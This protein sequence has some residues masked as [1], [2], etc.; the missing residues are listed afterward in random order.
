MRKHL[1]EH[2][3]PPIWTSKIK[4]QSSFS[5]PPFWTVF[6]KFYIDLSK[7]ISLLVSLS[8]S[9]G[10]QHGIQNQRSGAKMAAKHCAAL[11]FFQSWFLHAFGSPF[12]N[13]LVPVAPLLQDVH[14][15]CQYITKKWL[16]SNCQHPK[17]GVDSFG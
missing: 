16:P 10:R 1:F 6:V 15:F 12:G 13:L 8:K 3:G 7:K 11:T 17:A 9:S 14:L 4:Q 2:L 5:P